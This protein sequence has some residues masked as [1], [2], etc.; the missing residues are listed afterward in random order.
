M[1]SAS[2]FTRGGPVGD[3]YHG[4]KSDDFHVSPPTEVYTA[5]QGVAEFPQHVV[6][7]TTLAPDRGGS[8]AVPTMLRQSVLALDTGQ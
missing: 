1:I 7:S 5:V 4:L 8:V 6:P 3:V 2:L